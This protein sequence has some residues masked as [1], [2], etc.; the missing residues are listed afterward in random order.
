[1][2]RICVF[3]GSSA[4]N[5]SL[6]AEVAA[7]LGGLLA[8]RGLGLVYGGGNVGLMNVLA[9]AVL[10]GGGEAIG[11]IPESLQ[12]RELAHQR[13]TEIHVVPT[14]H[15]RKRVMA[16]LAD[17]FIALPGGMGTLDELCEI[18]TGAQLGFHAKPCGMVNVGGYYDKF[19]EMLDQAV[20][21]GFLRERHRALLLVEERPAALLQRMLA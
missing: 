10:Q 12:T 4:G 7:G 5:S 14:L 11:V 8:E 3:C 19:L 1:M 20:Q 15:D 16:D 13:L 6:Y 2:K 21:A 17:G 18:L 9:D